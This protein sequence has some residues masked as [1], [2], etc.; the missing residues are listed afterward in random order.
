MGRVSSLQ[1]AAEEYEFRGE[2]CKLL[3]RKFRLPPGRPIPVFFDL[4][5]IV[6]E[7][8]VLTLTHFYQNQIGIEPLDRFHTAAAFML[9]GQPR[10]RIE[11]DCQEDEAEDEMALL[12][13][14]F[15]LPG[16][17]DS[18]TSQE[19]T[20]RDEKAKPETKAE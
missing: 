11:L 14:F 10:T 20:M 15:E 19:Q 13:R 7:R 6:G 16:S 4:D 17:L 2:H 18:T 9:L 1:N 5:L 12:K 3:I 8:N